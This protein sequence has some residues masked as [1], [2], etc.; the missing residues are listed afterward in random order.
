MQ[1]LVYHRDVDVVQIDFTRP[2]SACVFAPVVPQVSD[3]LSA[4]DVRGLVEFGGSVAENG[5]V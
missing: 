1:E 2:Q 4:E 5:A 3:D